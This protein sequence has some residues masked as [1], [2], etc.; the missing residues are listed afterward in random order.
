MERQAIEGHFESAHPVTRPQLHGAIP[1]AQLIAAHNARMA[2]LT[3]QTQRTSMPNALANSSGAIS[4]GLE[5]RPGLPAGSYPT[6]VVTGDFNRDGHQD[7][8]VAN[9]DGNDLWIYFGNGDGTFDLPRIVPLTKG[10]GPDYLV[11]A[12]LRGDGNV[13]LVVAEFGSSTIGVLLGNGDGTFQLEQEYAL[14]EP[15]GALAVADFNHDGKLDIAAA[16]VTYTTPSY[17]NPGPPYIAMLAG[18][19]DG[20]FSSPV[21]TYSSG[22][23]SN[24]VDL[25]AADVNG[26]GLPDLMITGFGFDNSTI[27][28]N[29]GDGT[30][31][32]GPLVIGNGDF[33]TV[34]GGRL[35]DVNGDGC[36]DAIV[37]DLNGV[38]WIRLGDCAGNFAAPT[39]IP[40]G[41]ANAAVRVVDV[42]GDGHPD[43][44]AS[45]EV[46][47][48]SNFYYTAGNTISVALGDG[49]GNFGLAHIYGGNSEALSLTVGDFKGNS[50]PSIVTAD[51]DTD[52]AT[53]YANDGNGGFG[54]P[55]GIY[56]CQA[57]TSARVC[58]DLNLAGG[59]GYTFA[60]L[61]GDGKPDIFQIGSSVDIENSGPTYSYF[62]LSFLND[63]F[64]HFG[65]V[66]ASPFLTDT[67][68]T[69]FGDYKLS[70]F[71][72][73]GHLDLVAI[74]V[75][76]AYTTSQQFIVF[77]PGNGDGTFGKATVTSVSGADGL[78]ATGDFNGD[79]KLDFVAVNGA[80]SHILTTF[81]GNGDGTFRTGASLNF[82]DTNNDIARVFAGDFNRDGK[83]D[84]LVFATSNGYG[85]S[86]SAVWEFDGNGDGTFQPGR[87][88][89]TG[90]DSIGLGDINN[91]GHPDIARFDFFQTNSSS[92]FLA[93]PQITNYLGQPDG[94]FQ[95]VSSYSPYNDTPLELEPY[96]QFGDPQTVSVTGDYNADGKIDEV[97]FQSGPV[98]YAQMLMGNG[99]GTFTPT[100]DIFPF[101]PY[102]YPVYG[103]DFDGDGFTDMLSLD[104][105]S[106]GMMIQRG[107]PAPALQIALE[108]P[109]VTGN[110]GCGWVYPDVASSSSQTVA[111]SSSVS[112]VTL[113]GSVTIPA[114]ALSAQF[115][116][117]LASNFNWRQAFDINATLNGSTA[118]AY[119]SDSYVVGFSE[120]V[121][122][123][124]PAAVYQGQSSA[125]LTL[126]LTAQPGYSSTAN[127]YCEGLTQGDSC[128]FGS[129]TLSVSPSGPVS[130][131]VTLVT[132]ANAVTYGNS[133][134][135]TIAADDGDVIQRQTVSL[136]AAKLDIAAQTP[137]NIS[138]LAPGSGTQAF[139]VN[140]IPPYQF[141]CSGLPA[142][143]SCSFS[144]IQQPFPS[145]SVI[146]ATVNVSA[147]TANGNY[148]FTVTATSQS[149]TASAQETLQVD[150]YSI[151]GPSAGSDWAFPGT[152]Q[153][154]PI[155]V[156]GSS[157]W[158]GGPVAISCSLD[159]AA[160]C[161]GGTI[162]PGSTA[163]AP[164]NLSLNLPA[165]TAL[166]QHQLSVTGTI[167]GSTQTYTFPIY[168]VSLSGS[169]N[170][171]TLTMAQGGSG[172][173][174]ATLNASTGF[175]DSVSLACSGTSELTCSFNPSDPQV[176]GTTGQTVSITITANAT[177]LLK[178]KPGL[179]PARNLIALTVLFP[180]ALCCGFLR[181]RRGNVL[182]VFLLGFVVF[183]F[184]GACGGGGGGAGGSGGGGE[185]GGGG[186][187]NTYSLTVTA[188]PGNTSTVTTLGTVT[189]TVTH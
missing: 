85:T 16:M 49:K 17:V 48:E 47:Q 176:T 36:P 174:T 27:Y 20:T 108:E 42:N 25:D 92:G 3:R 170:A 22:F 125:P 127:L 39:S 11:A 66:F 95:Q 80:Q 87:E 177:A 167:A 150:S 104:W 9:G 188:T 158:S 61:N 19:G 135:F 24:V 33:N 98:A 151:Q 96:A 105:G 65:P 63:G 89:S 86:G 88:L 169:F 40:I 114:G 152:P 112:G 164:M 99:D 91:D 185:G 161:T 137:F 60:D 82:S 58:P 77:Q 142:G 38:I 23:Y 110:Q 101:T 97:A 128:Q 157:N 100:Y 119:A 175:S 123:V 71:R 181:K 113:P 154:I 117:S 28:L 30:F 83:L 13:D 34:S 138:S 67:T 59:S 21:I 179:S 159:I 53:V 145:V 129:N 69:Q 79:G 68:Y 44:I 186:G 8:V 84:V 78:M 2:L 162:T 51:I 144:G 32:E 136:G 73:T 189:V 182:L 149:Y 70:D 94:T 54:F 81:L 178:S 139:S 132:A 111:L 46:F 171:S 56:A 148:P 52:T 184:V 122:A 7:F 6:S 147:G 168:I 64:G 146:D 74:G 4:P 18:N 165:G 124:T 106:G 31:R 76:T 37:A 140:G 109:I 41:Q 26:D 90:F 72:N 43:L 155:S 143:V 173:L 115:C 55:Q 166:G 15:P 141:D 131:T 120:A 57:N 5:M 1:G 35:V 126:T 75:N 93:S 187:S 45:S 103:H 121:S 163:A 160:T 118:T 130:T 183:T 14:P 107:A 133:H 180:L 29:N 12:D 156:Q 153:S 134:S 10:V 62:S 102:V 50:R 172:T 116:Y